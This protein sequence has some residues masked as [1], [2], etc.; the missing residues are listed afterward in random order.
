MIGTFIFWQTSAKP[1]E[2]RESIEEKKKIS[3]KPNH[4]AT[5]YTLLTTEKII[6]EHFQHY[7]KRRRLTI[8]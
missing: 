6:L 5:V 8:I 4:Y 2:E 3:L 1:G 7:L